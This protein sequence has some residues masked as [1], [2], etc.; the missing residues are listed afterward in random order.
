[1]VDEAIKAIMERSMAVNAEIPFAQYILLVVLAILCVLFIEIR[2]EEKIAFLDVGQGDA[3]F[4]QDG[5]SQVIIDGGEGSVLLERLAE[6]MP[7]F[8][9]HIE[10]LIPTHPQRD[11][12]EGLVHALERYEVGLII[13]PRVVN[14][15]LLQ[16]E[17]IAK[18]IEKNIPYR[19][20]WAGQTIHVGDIHITVVGPFDSDQAEKLAKVDVNNASVMT[21]IDYHDMSLL[22]TGDAEAPA[23]QLL[24]RSVSA[25]VLNVDVLKAGHHGSRTSTTDQLVQAASPSVVTISVGEENTFGH[26]HST[27]LSRLQSLPVLRT[28]QMGTIRFV[29]YQDEWRLHQRLG[30]L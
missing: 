17:L 19:F 27:V 15:S 8:D 1:M 10:V 20:A 29:R 18:I 16:E 5:S 12:V 30:I 28:D 24:V 11:H 22:L 4:F 26:P 14:D 13:L 7:W 25:D 21:R 2:A 23:E 3:I 6:E 9:R